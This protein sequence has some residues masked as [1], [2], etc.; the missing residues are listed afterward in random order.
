MESKTILEG[1]EKICGVIDGLT[2]E[3]KVNPKQNKRDV[4]RNKPV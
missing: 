2:L 1:V 4:A 3:E